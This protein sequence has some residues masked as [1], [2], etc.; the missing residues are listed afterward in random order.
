MAPS[1]RKH[2]DPSLYQIPS[3]LTDVCKL[4]P[5]SCTFPY[6]PFPYSFPAHLTLASLFL[7]PAVRMLSHHRTGNSQVH[8]QSSIL[9][10]SCN[11]S[12]RV[13]QSLPD[14]AQT[15]SGFSYK[16]QAPSCPHRNA[17]EQDIPDLPPLFLY[18]RQS[19]TVHRP[20]P[21]IPVSYFFSPDLALPPEQTLPKAAETP[22][23]S[24]F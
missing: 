19:H 21:C 7:P 1:Y 5:F 8:L 17:K 9:S 18:C 2:A 14:P 4:R 6:H 12:Y 16:I 20:S 10:L 23:L 3:D 24:R 13:Y 11:S 15:L 22:S